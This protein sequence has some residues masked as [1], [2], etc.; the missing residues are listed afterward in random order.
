M[1]GRIAW[2]SWSWLLVVLLLPLLGVLAV[3]QYRWTGELSRGERDRTETGLRRAMNGL[4]SDFDEEITRLF[5]HFQSALLTATATGESP[6]ALVTE[7]VEIWREEARYP[8][9]IRD[10]FFADLEKDEEKGSPSLIDADGATMDWPSELAAVREVLEASHGSERLPKPI[11][12]EGPALVL[13]LSPLS[14]LEAARHRSRADQRSGPDSRSRQRPDRRGR[15]QSWRDER[16]GPP[17]S[18]ESALEAQPRRYLVLW[19]DLET[20][21]QGIWTDLVAH[22]FT[23]D[24]T[25]TLDFQLTVLEAEGRDVLFRQGPRAHQPRGGDRK[26]GDVLPHSPA[27]YGP[28]GSR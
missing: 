12:A 9:L 28:K 2:D 21:E 7:R 19:L 6:E 23:P 18:G 4:A 14:W 22:H 3:L 20:I 15:R 11:I 5:S 27:G 26:R 16:G 13:P 17:G 24:G 10:W 1:S 25:G 8:D